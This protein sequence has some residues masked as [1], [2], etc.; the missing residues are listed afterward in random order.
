MVTVVHQAIELDWLKAE[1]LD[2]PLTLVIGSFNPFNPNGDGNLDYYYGR[3]TNHFWKSIA[4]NIKKPDK[5]FFNN[6]HGLTRKIEVMKGKFCCLDVINSID[7]DCE[8]AEIL[9]EYLNNKI[10]GDFNDQTIWTTNTNWKGEKINL[11]RSYN[12][13]I[14]TLLQ[15]S[16]SIRKVIHTM[17]VG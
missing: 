16:Q 10:F 13:S 12:P 2:N 4:R 15:N 17:G 6:E 5:F 8:N 7:I 11:K 1:D 3:G 14:K 9:H